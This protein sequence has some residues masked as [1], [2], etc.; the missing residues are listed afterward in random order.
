MCNT[1]F[2]YNVDLRKR[3]L[4]STLWFGVKFCITGQVQ[5]HSYD[6]Y[7]LLVTF[8]R[9]A[10]CCHPRPNRSSCQVPSCI[11]TWRVV[12]M[13]WALTSLVNKRPFI[14]GWIN[15][16]PLPST[17]QTHIYTYSPM[18]ESENHAGESAT[19]SEPRHKEEEKK[20]TNADNPL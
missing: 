4:G 13:A 7:W 2:P 9:C 6:N 20:Q 14:E 18:K 11:D 19:S 3:F 16:F 10:T 15:F 12:G 1:C 5:G 17:S 8:S